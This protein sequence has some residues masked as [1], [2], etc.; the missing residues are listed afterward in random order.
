[1]S[2]ADAATQLKRFASGLVGPSR[3]ELVR[4]RDQLLMAPPPAPDSMVDVPP[5]CACASCTS[6]ATE[7]RE[8]RIRHAA[9]HGRVTVLERQLAALTWGTEKERDAPGEALAELADE[10][11]RAFDQ[12]KARAWTRRVVVDGRGRERAFE[13]LSVITEVSTVVLALYRQ[14]RERLPFLATAE[15]LA[16]IAEA[17]RQKDAALARPLERPLDPEVARRAGTTRAPEA[18]DESNGLAVDPS[19][20]SVLGGSIRFKRRG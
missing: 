20:P 19:N 14:A 2:L 11:L 16:A 12:N 7:T 18:V 8:V 1:M 5:T 13:T 17:R 3:D 10:L 6:A 15:L 4:E 9:W